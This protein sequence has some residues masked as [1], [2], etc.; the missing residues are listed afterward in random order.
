MAGNH[1]IGQGGYGGN[2]TIECFSKNKV[3][4]IGEPTT[5]SG[6]PFTG[7]NISRRPLRTVRMGVY[8]ASGNDGNI[9]TVTGDVAFI[10]K[11]NNGSTNSPGDFYGF[12]KEKK[13]RITLN[14][15]K[16]RAEI[17]NIYVKYEEKKYAKLHVT[18]YSEKELPHS[19]V[20]TP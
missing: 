12:E 19:S 14:V 2:I 7:R 4:V 17:N 20:F 15:E 11:T 13:I 5:T 1:H 3:N 10:H 9:D 18:N 6:I 8:E 16:V